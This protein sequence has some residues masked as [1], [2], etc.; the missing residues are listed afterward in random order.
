M[1]PDDADTLM[2]SY[3]TDIKQAKK[4]IS[5]LSPSIND[6]SLI[7]SLKKLSKQNVPVVI[8]TQLPLDEANKISYLSLFKNISVFTLKASEYL[9]TRGSIICVDNQKSYYISN[10]LNQKKLKTDYAFGI[11]KEEACSYIFKTLLQRCTAY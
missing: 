10:A 3:N 9:N 6:F 4:T 8:I 1:L 11:Y 7:Y 2:Y 5:I